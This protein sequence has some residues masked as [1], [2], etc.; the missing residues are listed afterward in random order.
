[1]PERKE[2]LQVGPWPGHFQNFEPGEKKPTRHL[3]VQNFRLRSQK[4]GVH[5]PSPMHRSDPGT[6]RHFLAC[7]P[8]DVV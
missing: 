3:G 1:V 4:G 7:A 2:T 5:C 6:V 8:V